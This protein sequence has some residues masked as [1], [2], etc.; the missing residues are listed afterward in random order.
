MTRRRPIGFEEE[1]YKG[2]GRRMRA[3]RKALGLTQSE[4]AEKLELHKAQYPKYEAGY[5][6]MVDKLRRLTTVVP[7]IN[8]HWLLTGEGEP[9]TRLPTVPYNPEILEYKESKPP[10]LYSEDTEE[11]SL[12]AVPF[13]HDE[14]ANLQWGTY[15]FEEFPP[16]ALYFHKDFLKRVI[17]LPDFG[18]L[19]LVPVESDAMEPLIPQGSIAIARK[20]ENDGRIFDSNIYAL[21]LNNVVYFRKAVLTAED[22]ILLI[23]GVDKY[24]A[25]Q[26]KLDKARIIGRI[27]G[28]IRLL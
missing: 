15:S 3:L 10:S 27:I 20:L 1:F 7:E 23:S 28:C 14:E 4:M 18:G 17:R 9:F 5:R 8:Y 25:M 19:T 6:F 26:V 12:I 22:E 11:T 24:P 13:Y 16:A 2:L 21:I